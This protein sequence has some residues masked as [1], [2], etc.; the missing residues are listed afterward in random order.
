MESVRTLYGGRGLTLVAILLA[1]TILIPLGVILSSWWVV[2][3]AVWHHLA[4]TVLAELLV[5]TLLLAAGV[6]TGVMVL[7]SGLAWL[8]TLCQFP[9]R[10]FFDGVLILPLAIPAYV[11]AFTVLGFFDFG[12]PLQSWLSLVPGTVRLPNLRTPAWVITIL[13][14]VLYPYVYL[15]ARGAFLQQGQR[16]LE[17]SRVLGRGPW[18]AFFSAALPMARPAIVV[19][20]SLAV[21]EAMA[22]FGAVSVFNFNTFTTAI[23]KSWF[24][25]FNLNAAAQLASLLLLFVLLLLTLERSMRGLARFHG[26]D[27][28]RQPERIVL[29]GMA[30]FAAFALCALVFLC[31]FLLPMGQLLVW[32]WQSMARDLDTRYGQLLGHTLLLGSGAALLTTSGAFLLALA[33]RSGQRLRRWAVRVATLGYALPGSVLAVGV[34]VSFAWLEKGLG[35]VLL[36]G[37]VAGLLLA[38]ATRFL[39][40]AFGP[41]ES[42]MERIR[43]Q[44]AE[45]AITLGC[46]GTALIRRIYL[47]ILRPSLLTALLMVLVEVMKEMPATLLLR[48][49]GWDTLAVRIFEMT[50][51]GEWQ[52]AALPAVTL[53]LAGLLPVLLLLR[54][55]GR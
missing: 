50:S 27:G 30:A 55:S 8:T 18:G 9:G 10:R 31:A 21:M 35:F 24:G 25:L 36:T 28:L 29:H 26:A 39:A 52:R 43:P 37:S 13:V 12:G 6:G 38:Y 20:A 41:L 49:F 16:M 4:E 44:L 46:S 2:E 19:G 34:M 45:A 11:L 15:L 14:L 51:E 53:V 42:G 22:D 23:Y 7:G 40:V 3:A 48:P 1:M 47:P 32:A 5:N 33:V 54:R 17:A